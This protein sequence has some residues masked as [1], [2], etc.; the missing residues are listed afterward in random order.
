MNSGSEKRAALEYARSQG[1]IPPEEQAECA[2]FADRV[3]TSE[4]RVTELDRM[5]REEG[6]RLHV[7]EERAAEFEARLAA[8]VESHAVAKKVLLRARK[9]KAGQLEVA[10]REVL[11]A[12]DNDLVG[13]QRNPD[14]V[15]RALSAARELLE[16]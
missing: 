6:A 10:L 15:A 13:A 4:A 14:R 11:D 9:S 8:E 3:V 5:V 1:W 12:H 16:P 2:A 7:A